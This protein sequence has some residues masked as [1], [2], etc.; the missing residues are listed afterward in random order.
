MNKIIYKKRSQ[1]I[2]RKL[3]QVNSERLRLT[4]FRSS[5]NISAQI[6]D[7]KNNRT[8]VSAT[9]IKE[10][11]SSM[12]YKTTQSSMPSFSSKIFSTPRIHL[13]GQEPRHHLLLS[14]VCRRMNVLYNVA[15]LP[16]LPSSMSVVV[17]QDRSPQ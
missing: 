2:R 13:L 4:V 1:R 5:R 8:L 12:Q 3:R 16:Q 11:N 14:I 6:I 15:V 17:L 7:D 10:C 9:S